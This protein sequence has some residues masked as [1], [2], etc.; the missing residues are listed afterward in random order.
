MRDSPEDEVRNVKRLGVHLAVHGQESETAKIRGVDIGRRKNDFIQILPRPTVVI[1]V[2]ENVGLSRTSKRH[3][4]TQERDKYGS[5][6]IQACLEAAVS[7]FF[8]CS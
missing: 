3:R 1:V 5:I 8:P 2:G 7:S 6:G 4:Q